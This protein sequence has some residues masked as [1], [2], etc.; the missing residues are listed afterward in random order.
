M[1]TAYF[2]DS[3][4]I[5]PGQR[6]LQTRSPGQRPPKEHGTRDTHREPLERTWDQE[7]RQEVISYRVPPHPDRMTD[8]SENITLPQTSFVG[9]KNSF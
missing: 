5:P 2:S 4:Q 7:A 3:G 8:A 9:G 6:P 1:H